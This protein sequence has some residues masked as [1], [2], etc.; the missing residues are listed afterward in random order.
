MTEKYLIKY[1]ETFGENFPIYAFMATSENVIVD[2]IKRC[3]DNNRPYVL[4]IDKDVL[5]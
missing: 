3:L 5:Y 2:T 4:E 1:V